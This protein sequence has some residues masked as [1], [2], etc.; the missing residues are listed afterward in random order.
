MKIK[1]KNL[2]EG[3]VVLL[4][5]HERFLDEVS[6]SRDGMIELEYGDYTATDFVD[7]DEFIELA[8]TN[9]LG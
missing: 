2:R 8:R 9:Y 3:M 1:A 4:S 6:Y 5:G 7:P